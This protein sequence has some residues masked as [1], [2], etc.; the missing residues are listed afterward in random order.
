MPGVEFTR[1]LPFLHFGEGVL[2]EFRYKGH[3]FEIAS[4]WA[5][6]HVCP[7]DQVPAYPEIV[8]IQEFFEQN[9]QCSFAMW[10]I[11][12]FRRKKA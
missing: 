10:V 2:A 5:D 4:V 3:D 7:K 1:P 9:A 6:I 11:G 12:L 8:E